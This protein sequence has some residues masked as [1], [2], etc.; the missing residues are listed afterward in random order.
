M[1]EC[2]ASELIA[3]AC[4]NGFVCLEP[5]MSRAVELQLWKNI[6]E[7]ENTLGQLVQQAC[8]NGFICVSLDERMGNAVEM[9]LL[10]NLTEA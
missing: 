3:E 2:P 6:A 9:Q 10:C 8:E 4:E 1:A 5:R 7:D